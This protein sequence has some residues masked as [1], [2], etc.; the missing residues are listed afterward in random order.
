MGSVSAVDK[1]TIVTYPDDFSKHE[2]TEL[3]IAAGYSVQALIT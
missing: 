3:A 1:V 2:I